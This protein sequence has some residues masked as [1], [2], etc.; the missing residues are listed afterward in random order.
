MKFLLHSNAVIRIIAGNS[1]LISRLAEH[2][3]NDSAVPSVVMSELYFGAYNSGRAA[4]NADRV[5]ALRFE[6]LELCPLPMRESL[7]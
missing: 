7:A 3:P 1:G 2:V 6:V 5:N 4:D